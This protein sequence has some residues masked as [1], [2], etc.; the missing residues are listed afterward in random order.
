[1]RVR[2]TPAAVDDLEEISN[3]LKTHHPRYWQPTIRKLYEQIR[4]LRE[5]PNSGRLGRES[6]TREVV[7]SPLPYIAVYRV[8]DDRIEILRIRHAARNVS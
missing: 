1:M 3:Y 2:W 4:S 8:K 6:G 7:L 5:W